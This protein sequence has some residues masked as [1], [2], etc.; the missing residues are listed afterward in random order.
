MSDLVKTARDSHEMAHKRFM[1]LPLDERNHLDQGLLDAVDD[2]LSHLEAQQSKAVGE[3][4]P[5][6]ATEQAT[7]CDH[8]ILDLGGGRRGCGRCRRLGTWEDGMIRWDQQWEAFNG[9]VAVGDKLRRRDDQ[10]KVYTVQ[11]MEDDAVY[12]VGG[13]RKYLE[14][15]GSVV[16]TLSKWEIA[17]NIHGQQHTW[18]T[19][20]KREQK[21]NLT[22]LMRYGRGRETGSLLATPCFAGESSKSLPMNG[23][24]P[25]PDADGWRRVTDKYTP[26]VGDLLRQPHMTEPIVVKEVNAY[27]SFLVNIQMQDG[28]L[29]WELKHITSND[30]FYR[31]PSQPATEQKAA[32]TE[33]TAEEVNDAIAGEW[34]VKQ[35]N[36]IVRPEGSYKPHWDNLSPTL[37]LI[38]RRALQQPQPSQPTTEQK[39]AATGTA[40]VERLK[41]VLHRDQTGMAHALAEVVEV[42]KGFRWVTEGRGPYTWDDDEYRKEMGRMLDK[43]GGLASDA[44]QKS[45]DLAHRECCGRGRHQPSQP[46]PAP[47]V[48]KGVEEIAKE[49][50]NGLK[51]IVIGSRDQVQISQSELLE[52][53]QR[54]I[55]LDRASRHSPDREAILNEWDNLPAVSQNNPQ[56]MADAAIAL[57]REC[58]KGTP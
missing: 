24:Q 22:T 40:E 49:V 55:R 37:K 50:C 53:I 47:E 12:F 18:P 36:Q 51:L 57:F 14:D 21:C 15:L 45:G 17:R 2:I 58:N 9:L 26:Q 1:Q 38:I 28:W 16:N 13:G 31:R 32:A 33:R 34:F 42:V 4:P 5:T 20:G 11:R 27:G 48:E 39:A 44:L 8:E 41:D 52:I 19:S 46:T 56:A 30:W 35:I 29:Q 3:Q 43:I 6:Q 54:A 23:E 7:C 10:T 25:H